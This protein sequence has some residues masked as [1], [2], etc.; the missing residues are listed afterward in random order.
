MKK[1]L[2]TFAFLLML[3]SSN[4]LFAGNG[5]EEKDNKEKDTEETM[6]SIHQMDSVRLGGEQDLIMEVDSAHQD[7][8]LHKYNFLFYFIY[9]MKFQYEE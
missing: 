8:S 6:R 1:Y 2:S 4:L 9:K 3:L 7:D 5:G